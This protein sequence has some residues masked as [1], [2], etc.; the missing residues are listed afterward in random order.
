MSSHVI[1]VGFNP[2]HEYS[3]V[4][5]VIG[6]YGSDISDRIEVMI[7][8]CEKAL[9]LAARDTLVVYSSPG[10]QH[11]V[12]EA[13]TAYKQNIL[14]CSPMGS[15]SHDELSILTKVPCVVITGGSSDNQG[16]TTGYGTGLEFWDYDIYSSNS[17]ALIAGK[18]LKIKDTLGCSWWEARYR[19]RQT[20]YRSLATHPLGEHVNKYHGYGKI[21]VNDAIAWTGIIPVDPYIIRGRKNN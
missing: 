8:T 19:A 10:I 11:L 20:A 14:L 9:S 13:T 18:L 4:P 21:M 5:Y 16:C 15:N 6:G 1:V 3:M 12:D 17:N 2:D 7:N